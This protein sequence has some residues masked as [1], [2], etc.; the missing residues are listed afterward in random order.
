MWMIKWHPNNKKKKEIQDDRAQ[1]ENWDLAIKKDIKNKRDLMQ[2]DKSD[3]DDTKET[4][5]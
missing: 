2:V 5:H 1:Q 4:T 3:K